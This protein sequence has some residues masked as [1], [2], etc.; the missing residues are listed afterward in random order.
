MKTIILSCAMIICHFHLISQCTNTIL[1]PTNPI[2]VDVFGTNTQ[3]ISTQN[4][5]GDYFN[6]ESLKEGETYTLTSS[7]ADYYTLYDTNTGALLGHGPQPYNFIPAAGV[8][9][10]TAHLNSDN[11]CLTDGESRTT[12]IQCSTCSPVSIGIG[13]S[14]PHPSAR[15]EV[16]STNQGILLPRNDPSQIQNPTRG[17]MTYDVTA[18][19]VKVY[20]GNSWISLDGWEDEEEEILTSVRT[21]EK[22][23]DY[24]SFFPPQNS[25]EIYNS[26]ITGRWVTVGSAMYASVVIPANATITEFTGYVYDSSSSNSGLLSLLRIPLGQNS[27]G[28]QVEFLSSSVNP[29]LTTIQT[30]TKPINEFVN[31][32][33][34]YFVRFSNYN[35][36]NVRIRAVKIK[37]TLPIFD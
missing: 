29:P 10:V 1:Y 23:I 21:Y 36:T 6:L 19:E 32:A 17:L 11:N 15:L 24:H 22:V 33:N 7:S 13:T 12:R 3:L 4:F 28:T 14:T 25:T 9:K 27:A 37:Y 35:D 16:S 20:S 26:S 18:N 31:A 5:S 8:T 34:S 30:L 2:V